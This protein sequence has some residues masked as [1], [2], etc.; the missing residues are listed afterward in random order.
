M[1]QP[2]YKR[3]GTRHGRS[4][5][6]MVISLL[7]KNPPTLLSD[8]STHHRTPDPRDL[9]LSDWPGKHWQIFRGTCSKTLLPPGSPPPPKTRAARVGPWC[10][11]VSTWTLSVRGRAAGTQKGPSAQ[12]AKAHLGWLA[13]QPLLKPPFH[14]PNCSP[15]Q[16]SGKSQEVPHRPSPFRSLLHLG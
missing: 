12:P 10:H 16:P 13:S 8:L 14:P 9:W 5:R 7:S 2:S 4:Y 6:P 11:L 15:D 3:P 1:S